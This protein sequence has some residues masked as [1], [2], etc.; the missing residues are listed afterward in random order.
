MSTLTER[1]I[2]R[3]A[4]SGPI[5]LAE[6]MGLALADPEAG[7]YTTN[8]PIG[9]PAVTP[10][11][12]QGDFVTAP[13]ISQMFGE[14][15]GLWCVDTWD[16]LGRPRPFQLVELGPGRGTL[17][18]DALRAARVVPAFLEA[19]SLHLVEISPTLRSQQ[20]ARLA[21]CGVTPQ[22]HASLEDL[23]ALPM[24]LIANEFFD[25]LPIRQFERIDNSWAERL[26]GLDADGES[27]CFHLGPASPLLSHL[28]PL[29]LRAGS[30]KEDPGGQVVEVSPASLWIA[31]EISRRL[32]AKG[33]AALI[34][35][36]GHAEPRYGITLQAVRGH[37]RWDVLRDPGAADLTAH[38][39]FASLAAAAQAEGAT[40][41]GPVDQGPFLASLGLA[42]RAERLV[43]T[44]GPQQREDIQAAVTRLTDPAE[45]GTLFKVL[46]LCQGKAPS[47]AGFSA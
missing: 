39:D 35:D 18:E 21:E 12:A 2:R 34:V 32:A 38:V 5:S 44:A 10:K 43:A 42:A 8:T 29:A 24:I 15:I 20:Q 26:V 46:A 40:A 4:R 45:M 36:Y 33:G 41:L 6:Y 22:W 7:Y 31:A 1:L 25:A 37:G 17:L 16:R 47:L 11:G 27:F 30:E 14:L 19:L 3:I 28:V 23:P 9:A 13:E